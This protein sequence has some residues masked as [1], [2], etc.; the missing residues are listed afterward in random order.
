MDSDFS[1]A[2]LDFC[3]DDNSMFN[4]YDQSSTNTFSDQTMDNS[5]NPLSEE[6]KLLSQLKQNQI[7]INQKLKR[8]EELTKAETK[9]KRWDQNECEQFNQGLEVHW[10]NIK[11]VEKFVPTKSSRQVISHSQK[12][13]LKLQNSLQGRFVPI[14]L[15][16][17]QQKINHEPKMTLQQAVAKCQG[18]NTF[19]I[20]RKTINATQAA[21]SVIIGI[22]FVE[23]TEGLDYDVIEAI[24]VGWQ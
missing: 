3:D 19:D 16:D 8:I 20:V 23:E 12:F 4:I 1:I 10:R 9:V 17:A 5:L 11:S 21:G 15:K 7:I 6:Q 14:L 13:F 22:K 18:K 24:L 2:P